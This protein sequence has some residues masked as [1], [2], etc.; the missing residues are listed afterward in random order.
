MKINKSTIHLEYPKN[1][2]TC[3]TWHVAQIDSMP[4]MLSQTMTKQC[5]EIM[6]PLEFS[7]PSQKQV[8][9]TPRFT[10]SS[11]HNTKYRRGARRRTIQIRSNSKVHQVPFTLEDF[12]H[13]VPRRKADRFFKYVGRKQSATGATSMVF[14]TL[15]NSGTSM[16]M[17][18]EPSRILAQPSGTLRRST[19]AILLKFRIS[20]K[21]S[22]FA[23]KHEIK[24]I[25]QSFSNRL[26]QRKNQVDH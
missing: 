13:V 2:F 10:V 23:L 11:S 19:V 18:L 14:H 17:L 4:Q 1:S 22:G 15:L 25:C 6:M 5:L 9:V 21:G 8:S 7:R 24:L 12:I 26:E 3:S 16:T 20:A